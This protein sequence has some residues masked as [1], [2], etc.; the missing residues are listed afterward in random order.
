MDEELWLNGT[1]H[2]M[3]SVLRR[4]HARL[5]RPVSERALRFFALACCRLAW[6]AL[7]DERSRR[8]VEVAER[9]MVEQATPEELAVAVAEAAAARDEAEALS[10]QSHSTAR[11][12]AAIAARVA[13]FVV[14]RGFDQ[15]IFAKV[16]DALT[17]QRGVTD[18]AEVRAFVGQLTRAL[19][20]VYANPFRPVAFSPAWR[21]DTAVALARQ[22]YEAREFG[23]MP[24]LADAL[25]DA[26]CDCEEVLTHCRDT[27]APHVR[28]CWVVDLVLGKE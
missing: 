7:V 2:Q 23:A 26:G 6:P 20:E 13:A 18:R 21:T 24:I 28:G 22:M 16:R 5:D 17:F 9:A 8:A 4:V 3:L 19:R 10:E 12:G 15:G 11:F 25:Q 1:P 27:N 14:A